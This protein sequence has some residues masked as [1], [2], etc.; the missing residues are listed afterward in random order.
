M[1]AACERR[2]QGPTASLLPSDVNVRTV[3]KNPFILIR[4]CQ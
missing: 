4:K 2:A 3:K 1:G